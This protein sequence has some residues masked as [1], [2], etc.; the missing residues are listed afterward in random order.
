MKF[1]PYSW[2]KYPHRLDLMQHGSDVIY[3]GEFLQQGDKNFSLLLRSCLRCRKQIVTLLLWVKPC[4][5]DAESGVVEETIWTKEQPGHEKDL[6]PFTTIAGKLETTDTTQ[7]SRS[8][9]CERIR[10]SKPAEK[11]QRS[12]GARIQENDHFK[13]HSLNDLREAARIF[14]ESKISNEKSNF[15]FILPKHPFL[16]TSFKKNILKFQRL[17]LRLKF[18][19]VWKFVKKAVFAL[20]KWSNHH[21]TLGRC[22]QR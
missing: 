17:F 15:F 21:A 11:L 14:R 1:F 4:T 3:W 13:Q 10:Q 18:K 7:P 8:N 20:P 22:W 2:R 12:S 9:L 19:K 6:A 5:S 16:W